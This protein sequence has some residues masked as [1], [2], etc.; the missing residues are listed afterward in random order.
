MTAPYRTEAQRFYVR[1]DSSYRRPSDLD[2]KRI[3]VRA[4]C[5]VEP[6]LKG[7][8]ELA[9]VRLTRKLERPRSSPTTSTRPGSRTSA[10]ANS[11]AMRATRT[12]ASRRS[13]KGSRSA[14]WTS[15][16]RGVPDRFPGVPSVQGRRAL[17]CECTRP[18]WP[19]SARA[20]E[21]AD[22]P[23]E[24]RNGLSAVAAKYKGLEVA[25]VLEPRRRGLL[26]GLRPAPLAPE[27]QS[28]PR[29]ARVRRALLQRAL[30]RPPGAT[31]RSTPAT[32]ATRATSS[33]AGARTS[34]TRSRD[35]HAVPRDQRTVVTSGRDRVSVARSA[36]APASVG[37]Q[38][39][40]RDVRASPPA[41]RDARVGR[42][43]CA[44][45][46][47]SSPGALQGTAWAL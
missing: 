11:T 9:G 6:Y 38:P 41:L 13:R 37:A 7:E 4:S 16:L 5:S 18:P 2:G 43:A 23:D 10:G 46:G 31:S 39:V 3:G 44:P 15:G 17:T 8:L 36:A 26:R 19:L 20:V 21:G 45:P 32:S 24:T 47:P 22:D 25:A 27:P 35:S 30:P 28:D 1:E 29:M 33:P 42:G 14:P 40:S 34:R 12:S